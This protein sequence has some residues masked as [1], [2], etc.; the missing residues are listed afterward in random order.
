MRKEIVISIKK[1]VI[2]FKTRSNVLTAIRNISFDIYDGETLAI[3]GESGSGKSVMTKTFTNMLENNGWISN[4]S[5]VYSPST[6]ILADELAYFKKP[7]HLVDFH[8]ILLDSSLRKS[9]MKYNKKLIT[10]TEQKIKII[11][12]LQLEPVK[13][14]I[15]QLKAKEQELKKQISFTHSNRLN[16]KLVKVSTLIKKMEKNEAMLLDDNLKAKNIELLQN[17]IIDYTN[18]ISK[19]KNLTWPEKH[20]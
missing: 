17:Q 5:I 3:V 6:N 15:T 11:N 12:S 1:L 8:K 10:K 7:V 2:K 13:A 9:I 18:E 19:I 20:Y 4:G 16:N 14:E